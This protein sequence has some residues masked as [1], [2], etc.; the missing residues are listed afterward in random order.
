MLSAMRTC[1]GKLFHDF[2]AATLKASSPNFKR[3]LGT[4]K[5]DLVAERR[6]VPRDYEETGC[7]TSVMYVRALPM[8]VRWTRRHSLNCIRASTGSQCSSIA[9]AEYATMGTYIQGSGELPINMVTRTQA[10]HES[11]GSVEDALW[12]CDGRVRQPG[13]QSVAVVES[14]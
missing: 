8:T 9:A 3:V 14:R 5:S 10:I 6:T 11:H 7:R 2:A 13:E 12:W 4:W 1:S